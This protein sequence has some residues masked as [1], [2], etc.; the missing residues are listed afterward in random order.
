M[1]VFHACCA[2]VT[3]VDDKKCDENITGRTADRLRM[4]EQACGLRSFLQLAWACWGRSCLLLRGLAFL[5]PM[6]FCT[7]NDDD[8]NNSNKKQ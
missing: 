5:N 7:Y 3:F 6:R 4:A 8:N 1:H 2:C